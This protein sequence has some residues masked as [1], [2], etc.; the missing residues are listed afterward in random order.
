MRVELFAL[1]VSQERDRV[2]ARVVLCVGLALA[3][4]LLMLSLHAALLVAFWDSY[5]L[6]VAVGMV[7]FYAIV[8]VTSL[9]MLRR[10]KRTQEEPFAATQQVLRQDVETL[11]ELGN[12]PS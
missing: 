6:E 4:F 7:A 12:P 11:R 8:V 5:R 10:R 2:V 9:L 1:E 3:A